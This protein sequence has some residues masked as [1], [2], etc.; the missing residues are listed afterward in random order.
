MLL[1]VLLE[2]AQVLRELPGAILLQLR[3]LFKSLLLVRTNIA[4]K[5]TTNNRSIN[6]DIATRNVR[7]S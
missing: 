6:A 5:S 2:E 1:E 4:E 3:F 7:G